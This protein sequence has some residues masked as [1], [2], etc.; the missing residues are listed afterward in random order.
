[1]AR[2]VEIRDPKTCPTSLHLKVGDMLIFSATG[3]HIRDGARS[4][5]F[6]GAYL[7]AVLALDGNI[8][9][10]AGNPN[11][12][13]FLAQAPGGATIDVVTGDPWRAF[14]TTKFELTIET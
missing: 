2:I 4:V 7:T 6:L 11:R 14:D 13:I 5:Q 1:M 3:G 10:P 8:I 12:T 9:A